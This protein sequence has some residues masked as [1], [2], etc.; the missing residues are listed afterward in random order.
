M[1]PIGVVARQTGID[2]STLRK[3]ET[4]YGFPRPVRGAS[5]QRKY[6]ASELQTLVHIARRIAAGER[7]GGIMQELSADRQPPVVLHAE[8][9]TGP[10]H[11]P[12]VATALASVRA[13]DLPSL[14]ILLE[15]VRRQGTLLE[16][17]EAFA[18]PLTVAV[19]DAWACGDVSVYAEHLFS[20]LLENMLL[21]EPGVSGLDADPVVLLT[22]L[23][24]ERHTQGL[25]MIHAVLGD[26]GVACLRLSSDLPITEIIAAC[27]VNRFRAVGISVSARYPPRLLRSEVFELRERLDGDVALWL[28]GGG[29]DCLRLLPPGTRAFA[30]LRE[31]I[32]AAR[33]LLP[34][35]GAGS[36]GRKR[37]R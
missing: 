30:S 22:T 8:N 12:F 10:E 7:V 31:L 16:F 5:G 28:G 14:R 13:C 24:G 35:S 23:S 26:A 6:S 2:I 9:L 11:S 34:I 17:V 19:G 36:P 4:R 3:W 1:L 15:K 33:A 37:T 20:A 21:R 25:S 32:D 27:E 18:A 29:V